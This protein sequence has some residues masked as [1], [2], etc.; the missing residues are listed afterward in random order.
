M[1]LLLW[2]A[3]TLIL[4]RMLNK[5]SNGRCYA[6]TVMSGKVVIVTGANSGIG[7]A[8]A[9]ELARRGA[10]VIAACRDDERGKAA[11]SSI[12]KRTGNQS[13]KYI[14][15]DLSSFDSIRKFVKEFKSSEAKLDVLINN[16]GAGGLGRKKTADGIV[17]DMQVNHFGPF[18]LTL[19]LVPI[20]RKSAPSRVV[21]VSSILHKFGTIARINEENAYG[22]FQTYCNSKLCNVL[23]SNELAR[24]L[25]GTGVVVNSLHPGQVNTSLYKATALEKLRSLVL[26][27][28]FKSPEE[29]AQTS[30][31][32]AVSDECDLVSGRY[33]ADCEEGNMSAKARDEGLAK[34]LWSMSEQLVKLRPEEAI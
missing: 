29:G 31:Y 8:T 5:L 24:R 21:I 20:L 2:V 13:V 28:F 18:L 32:L 34:R 9:L 16:A 26:Y 12:I 6:D 30:I 11:V 25:E 23:F 7:Y 14:H 1:W 3:A 22:Y 17:R 33:F 4:I 15:L 27:T 19:L 10:K